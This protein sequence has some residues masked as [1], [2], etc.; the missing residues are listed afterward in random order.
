[1]NKRK[2]RLVRVKVEFPLVY[3][4][5]LD[6]LPFGTS[7][8]FGALGLEAAA[9]RLGA[10]YHPGTGSS[11]IRLSSAKRDLDISA[12]WRAAQAKEER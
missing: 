10:R 5:D 9:A 7:V 1:M 11:H 8:L 4:G 6:E 12:A 3:D 2:S